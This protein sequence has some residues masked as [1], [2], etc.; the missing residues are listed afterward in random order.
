MTFSIMSQRFTVKRYGPAE[1][2]NGF[3]RPGSSTRF[4][5]KGSLQPLSG[6]E[7]LML[8]EGDRNKEI[9]NLFT[10]SR[11]NPSLEQGQRLGDHVLVRNECYIVRSVEP[12]LYH[13]MDHFK[14]RVERVNDTEDDQ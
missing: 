1:N 9:L 10:E 3:L 4:A 2:I 5:I 12:W 13:G 8:P 6:K 7:M 14:C 11:L